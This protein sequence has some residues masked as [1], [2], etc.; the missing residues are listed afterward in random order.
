MILRRFRQHVRE[1]NWFAVGLD[2]CV[3]IVGILLGLQI[4]DW[5]QYRND[6]VTEQEYME[7][8]LADAEYN[9][10][11]LKNVVIS[12]E[13]RAM[14]AKAALDKLMGQ[15]EEIEDPERLVFDLV[16]SVD[17]ASA[18]IVTG[19][20]DELIS[21][22]KFGLLTDVKLKTL[23]QN[24]AGTHRY[25]EGSLEN[26]RA[27]SP[28]PIPHTFKHVTY[29]PSDGDHL[30][31]IETVDWEGLRQDKDFVGAV[32]NGIGALQSFVEYRQS[33]LKSVQDVYGHL[34]CALYGQCL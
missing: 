34:N 33:Q 27:I 7:R 17:F 32:V 3:V 2:V 14:Q 18:Q 24:E 9:L 31:L 21:A 23:L 4:D 29:K 5:K 12:H 16:L 10:E 6:R 30:Q 25:I 22:G 20:Y 28:N 15:H 26:F 11:Q 19:T 8:L 13:S 1:Q